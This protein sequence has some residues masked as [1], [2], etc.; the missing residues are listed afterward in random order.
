V[1]QTFKETQ[2][3][4]PAITNLY[5]GLASGEIILYPLADLGAD[6]VVEETDWYQDAVAAE[7]EVIWTT[8]FIDASTGDTVVATAKAYYQGDT[9][10]GVV[11]A[12]VRV[13]TLIDIVNDIEIGETGFASILNESGKLVAHPD[14]SLINTDQ[15]DEA[16]YQEIEQ[17]EASGTV[18]YVADGQEKIMGFAK[19]PTTNWTIGGVVN[20]EEFA[21]KAQ[22]VIT[23]ILITLGIVVLLAIIVSLLR[24]VVLLNLFNQ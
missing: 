15:S 8:P 2:E 24:H 18:E 10:I 1:L 23:P 16:Y 4:T 17:A 9:L 12:D 20:K 7:G 14:E 6:F 11:A 5:T 21:E 13:S 3:T 22:S 19:N